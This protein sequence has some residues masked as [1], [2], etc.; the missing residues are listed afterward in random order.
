MVVPLLTINVVLGAFP[1][2]WHYII[3]RAGVC[4]YKYNNY[5][6]IYITYK[7][8]IR[9]MRV[10][11]LPPIRPSRC[12]REKRK[13]WSQ[14]AL[15]SSDYVRKYFDVKKRAFLCN[16]MRDFGRFYAKFLF[17]N[18]PRNNRCEIRAFA[19]KIMR[20]FPI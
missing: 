10:S 2:Y 9:I 14:I 7:V 17:V 6:Y 19:L 13:C 16:Y 20:V 18:Y 4:T 12:G 5:S 11:K 1:V 15:A 8:V 3:V